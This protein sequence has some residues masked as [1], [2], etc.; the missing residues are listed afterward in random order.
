[1]TRQ[2]A[3]DQPIAYVVDD[4]ESIRECLK[5]LLISVGFQAGAFGSAQDFLRLKR[6]NIPNCLILDVRLP[7]MSGLELQTE[8]GTRGDAIPIVFISGHADVPMGV[9]AIK[10]GAVDFLCK[11]FREQDLLDAV[12]AAT[13]IDVAKRTENAIFSKIWK[14]YGLLTPREK[15]VMGCVVS[16]MM[17]QQIACRLNLSKIT[18]K[19]HRASVVKKMEARSVAEFVRQA[20]AIAKHHRAATLTH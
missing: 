17:N 11:P 19:V 13:K 4:D 2:A 8:L 15:E 7:G 18:I 10:A 12:F 3:P 9:R 6:P 5:G 1:M 16:G 14:S 20:D